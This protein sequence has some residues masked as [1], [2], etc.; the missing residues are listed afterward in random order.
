MRIKDLLVGASSL[1]GSVIAD[2]VSPIWPEPQSISLGSASLNLASSFKFTQESSSELLNRAISRYETLLGLPSNGLEGALNSCVITTVDASE[3]SLDLHVDESYSLTVGADGQ[4]RI[5][6]QTVWGALR[7]MESFTQ[8]LKRTPEAGNVVMGFA[9]VSI[10]DQARFSHRGVMI[11]S[12]RHYLSVDAIRKVIDTLPA[13]KFNVLHWH[14]VDAQSFPLSLPSVPAL[15]Q[16]AY[17]SK[18]TYTAAD[19]TSIQ[20]YAQDRGV[21]VVFEVDVPGHAASWTAGYPHIMADC[22]VKY[23]YNIN[24]FALNPTLDETYS[25]LNSVLSDISAST[26]TKYVHIGGDEVVY[27]CWANDTSITS[28]MGDQGMTTYDQ[29]LGYF[30]EKADEQIFALGATPVHWEEVFSAGIRPDP[31]TIFQVW[32]EQS[33][34]Q[35]IVAAEYNVVASPSDV[36]YLDI[37]S[38]TWDVMY[39][40]DPTVGLSAAESKYILGG[41]TALWGER[42]DETNILQ[43]MYPRASAVAERLWS[44]ETVTDQDYAKQRLLIQ[45]CR[46]VQ[47]GFASAPVEPGYCPETYV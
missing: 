31:R 34:I 37:A 17:N 4:C 8:L 33:K 27:G 30:V 47:R 10:T 22:F 25:V 20:E 19:L 18:M 2:S 36:W 15:A 43:Q 24:D 38:N 39:A 41:E 26:G 6:S 35:A 14:T 32:T 7:G 40:Y 28:W 46:L 42:V 5:S 23:S 45:R 3:D 16:G 1:A 12:S 13:S 29:L 9:P 11:D 44:A 21:R